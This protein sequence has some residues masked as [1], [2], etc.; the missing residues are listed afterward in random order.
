MTALDF[1]KEELSLKPYDS[2]AIISLSLSYANLGFNK[3]AIEL[4]S[5]VTP[6]D[7][8]YANALYY[9]SLGYRGLEEW[10]KVPSY[11]NKAIEEYQKRLNSLDNTE[12]HNLSS[13]YISAEKYDSATIILESLL[14]KT[15]R[16]NE[17]I[18]I[19]RNLYYIHEYQNPNYSS[20]YNLI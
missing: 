9:I 16:E 11:A 14:D 8:Q 6:S 5:T 19:L 13:A 4:L 10:E 3:K 18:D 2:D 17:K 12:R 7:N 15:K 20:S 1:A